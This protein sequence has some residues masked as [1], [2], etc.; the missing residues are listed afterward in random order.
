MSDTIVAETLAALGLSAAAENAGVYAG[1]GR[2]LG[3]GEPLVSASPA[4]GRALATVR[5]GSAE[6]YDACLAA[7]AGARRAWA[8]TPAPARGEV[9]RQ[10]GDALRAKKAALGRLVSLE[11]GKIASEGLGEVQEAID[12]C[13][14]AVGMSRTIAGGVLPSERAGHTLLECWHPIGGVGVIT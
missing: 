6:D 11:M 8:E 10:I 2:W 1:G 9:V 3:S 14:M 12:V 13:D 5:Q 4:S 7:M